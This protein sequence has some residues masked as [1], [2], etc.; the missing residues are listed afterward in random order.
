[1]IAIRPVAAL[2]FCVLV[3]CAQTSRTVEIP[4]EELPFP[5]AREPSPAGS[6]VPAV[7]VRV[8]FS[9][10]GRLV[11]VDRTVSLDVPLDEAAIRALIEG[12][13]PTERRAGIGTELASPA[14]ILG[15]TVAAGTATVDV[16]GE[17]QRP[18]PPTR[19]ALRVAQVTWTLTEIPGVRAVSFSID[20]VTIAISTDGGQAVARPVVRSDFTS[21][22]PSG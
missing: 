9:R 5:V 22:A 15:V 6:L 10:A 21:L 20:G 13:S 2:V 11:A 19:V 12:P 3:A 18:A 14:S 4:A 17:F 7:R 1:M 8:Y 16:S